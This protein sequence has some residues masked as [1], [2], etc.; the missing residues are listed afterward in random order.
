[1]H[2]RKKRSI[3]LKV[4]RGPKINQS[5]KIIKYMVAPVALGI[6]AYQK[7]LNDGNKIGQNTFRKDI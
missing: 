1:M 3:S 5:L 4:V 7:G 2:S 6:L